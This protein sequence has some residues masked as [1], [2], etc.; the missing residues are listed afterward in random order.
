[1]F[2]DFPLLVVSLSTQHDRSPLV[3]KE[4]MPALPASIWLPLLRRKYVLK[5]IK[6]QNDLKSLSP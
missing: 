1:M 2:L 6:A 3:F 4:A 5:K